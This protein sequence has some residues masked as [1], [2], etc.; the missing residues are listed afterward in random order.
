VTEHPAAGDAD[1]APRRAYLTR[2]S[3]PREIAPGVFWL[4][5]CS[6]TGAWRG[7][8]AKEKARRHVY[9]NAYL[10]IG[11]EKS[12][13]VES[14]HSAHWSGVERGLDAVLA[15][16]PLDYVFP[17]HQE[18]PHC[19]NLSRLA[20]KYP[21]I[22]V[23]GD[24]RDYHLYFP[25]LRDESLRPAG[26]GTTIDLGG[27]EVEFLPALWH[28]LPMTQWLWASGPDVLFCVDGLQ[29]SHDH[30]ADDCGLVSTELATVPSGPFI[31]APALDTIKWAAYSDMAAISS[32]FVELM[33]RLRPQLVAP[34]HG[35]P[36]VGESRQLISNILDTIAEMSRPGAMSPTEASPAAEAVASPGR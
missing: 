28:D 20:A 17:S 9:T 10:I 7:K 16:R 21:E 3:P 30:W 24:V 13:M 6:D 27:T 36:I 1:T 29:Y 25:S 12:L 11:A 4:G 33:N 22:A 14:G 18:I 5:G 15:D 35:A 34:T 31:E 23:V 19:G 26:P 32:E 8:W 2:P